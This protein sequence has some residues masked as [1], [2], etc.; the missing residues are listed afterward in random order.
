[1]KHFQRSQLLESCNLEIFSPMMP[2]IVTT[3]CINKNYDNDD[4]PTTPL[5]AMDPNQPLPS[6]TPTKNVSSFASHLFLYNT[7]C[8]CSQLCAKRFGEKCMWEPQHQFAN[9]GNLRKVEA[10]ILVYCK[11]LLCGKFGDSYRRLGLFCIR[12][13]IPYS[14]GTETVKL[15]AIGQSEI[16]AFHVTF[17][18][19]FQKP[20]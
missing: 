8:F 9:K 4:E 19:G 16:F 1:M 13:I 15:R 5:P 12:E 7:C 6:P 17:T 10:K 18:L 20:I 14:L 3:P 2:P 11:S